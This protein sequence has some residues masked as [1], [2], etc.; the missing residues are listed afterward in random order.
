MKEFFYLF[1]GILVLGYL[2]QYKT[3]IKKDLLL[4]FCL[5]YIFTLIIFSIFIG[6]YLFQS[7]GKKFLDTNVGSFQVNSFG[8]LVAASLP[9]FL[10]SFKIKK[11]FKFRNYVLG[12]ILFSIFNVYFGHSRASLL[13]LGLSLSLFWYFLMRKRLSTSTKYF[14]MIS[15][16]FVLLLGICLLVFFPGD[17]VHAYLNTESLVIRISLWKIFIFNTIEHGLFFGL[18]PSTEWVHSVFQSSYLNRDDIQI[19]ENLI[20]F[21]NN[22]THAHNLYI[23]IFANFGIVGLGLFLWIGGYYLTYLIRSRK[24]LYSRISLVGIVAI[25]IQEFFDYTYPDLSTFLPMILF[26]FLSYREKPSQRITKV[27]IQNIVSLFIIVFVSLYSWNAKISERLKFE[28]SPFFLLDHF[29]NPYVNSGKPHGLIGFDRWN[30][31]YIDS[32]YPVDLEFSYFRGRLLEENGRD[33]TMYYKQCSSASSYK[34]G[35]VWGMK[36]SE[37]TDLLNKYQFFLK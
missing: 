5:Y 21:T 6:F 27:P 36:E 37:K 15:P 17:W 26:L 20:R 34:I 12:I 11:L 8:S 29:G 9:I 2:L 1:Y 19:Y 23:Q 10:L 33:G 18:G 22:F 24:F 4:Y 16:L 13:G 31:Y 14:I 3:K 30:P 7:E 35:C 25:F 28:T 32:I